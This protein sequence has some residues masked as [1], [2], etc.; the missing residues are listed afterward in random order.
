MR[1]FQLIAGSVTALA[2]CSVIAQPTFAQYILPGTAAGQGTSGMTVTKPANTSAANAAT[3][4][5]SASPFVD[6][7]YLAS[8]TF[9][10]T[11]FASGS[12]QFRAVG[13]VN[14]VSGAANVNAEYGDADTGSDGNP[15]PF[16][17]AGVSDANPESTDPAIQRPSIRAAFN[18][19][20]IVQ[21]IDG[22]G[23]PYTLDLIFQR[24]INDDNS[25]A[26]DNIPELIFLER[27][28]NSIYNVQV[29]TGGTFLNPIFA[30]NTITINSGNAAQARATGYYIDTVE[31]P[32]GQQ[33]AATGLD[34]NSFF[35]G[36]ASTIYGVRITDT[37][38]ADLYGN[39]LSAASTSQFVPVPEALQGDGFLSEPIVVPEAGTG[40]LTLLGSAGILG[41]VI[42]RRTSRTV[43]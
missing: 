39:F 24:G 35:N 36:T 33:L 5:T 6:D 22:E 1:Q 4:G 11:T 8:M 9:G 31:I 26:V 20:S 17:L 13:N 30:P 23:T 42:R 10:S 12:G 41:A 3:T 43:K 34:L 2:L 15:N 37:N 25:S 21:G 32:G 14:V 40:L 19:L 16:L 38:G 18:S 28:A 29:I 7:V 27:G